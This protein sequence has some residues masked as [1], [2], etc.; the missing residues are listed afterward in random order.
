M[1]TLRPA[2]AVQLMLRIFK[3]R[4]MKKMTIE[5]IVRELDDV[6]LQNLDAHIKGGFPFQQGTPYC[7][8][9]ANAI[10][11]PGNGKAERYLAYS[12]WCNSAESV[13]G[14]PLDDLENWWEGI[15]EE[16]EFI[17]PGH[18]PDLVRAVKAEVVRRSTINV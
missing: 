16:G 5:E 7:C 18:F 15:D 8:A 13:E 14:M 12:R 3:Q 10:N 1:A 9:V 2:L 11:E 17:S 4:R 6:S